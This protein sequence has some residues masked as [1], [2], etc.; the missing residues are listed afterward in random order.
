LLIRRIT[1]ISPAS[2]NPR[3]P[4]QDKQPT[5][6]YYRLFLSLIAQGKKIISDIWYRRKVYVSTFNLNVY[7]SCRAQQAKFY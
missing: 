2:R 6:R 4:P 5:V 7:S 1:R 3:R